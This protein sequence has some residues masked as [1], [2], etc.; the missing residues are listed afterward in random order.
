[1]ETGGPSLADLLAVE[2][3]EPRRPN[4][5]RT[6]PLEIIKL[7]PAVFQRRLPSTRRQSSELHLKDLTTA[8]NDH[9]RGIGPPMAPLLVTAIG[10]EFYLVD[11]HHRYAA[12]VA[13][14][15]QRQ[16][17]VHYFDKGVEAARSEALKANRTG[18]LPL[19]GPSKREAAWQIVVGPDR[20]S[21]AKIS[22]V[23]GVSTGLVSEMRRRFLEDPNRKDLTW[24]QVLTG[25]KFSQ[26]DIDFASRDLE[27]A[28]KLSKRMVKN[29]GQK[30]FASSSI[31]AMALGMI[32]D[33]LP[34]RLVREW[35]LRDSDGFRRLIKRLEA[36]DTWA[37]DI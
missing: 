21:R 36:D 25:K 6:L 32:E 29:L 17:P 30:A 22:E 11:G 19:D 28:T 31:L 14:K 27:S 4:G 2:A 7:A 10:S 18:K 1:M 26:D 13:S 8:I 5:P 15:H 33:D 12:Y 16:V 3:S 24:I 37:L 23:T 20:M 9:I 34:F 35:A